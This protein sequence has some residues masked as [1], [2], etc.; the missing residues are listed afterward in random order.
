MHNI[1][2]HPTVLSTEGGWL[3][4]QLALSSPCYSNTT[5]IHT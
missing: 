3:V 2:T 1:F 5:C 4:I